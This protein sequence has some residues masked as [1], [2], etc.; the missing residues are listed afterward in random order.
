MKLIFYL[1]FGILMGILIY[2][3]F[4]SS[5]ICILWS[6]LI[7]FPSFARSMPKYFLPF[8]Y[9][10]TCISINKPT[11][12]GFWYCILISCLVLTLSLTRSFIAS[13]PSEPFPTLLTQS[14]TV[15]PDSL[16]NT[17]KERW[18]N[19]FRQADQGL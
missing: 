4:F 9:C 13:N 12:R 8:F 14:T 16:H 10:N 1:Q 17:H 11:I 5:L 19:T 7:V 18:S 2:N 3:N 6:F 15:S